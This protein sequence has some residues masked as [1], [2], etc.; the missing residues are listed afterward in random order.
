[1]SG[2]AGTD[3]GGSPS[4]ICSAAVPSFYAVAAKAS[5][6]EDVV[7][8]CDALGNRLREL[9]ELAT[10]MGGATGEHLLDDCAAKGALYKAVRCFYV[11][12]AYL[13]AGRAS[14]AY[15]VFDRGV[16]RA[17]AAR[18]KQEE[19]AHPDPEALTLLDTLEERSLAWKGIAHVE[20]VAEE[21]R[22]AANA[23]DR[24]QSLQ[25]SDSDATEVAYLMD[26]LEEW[27]SFAGV[28]SQ[29]RLCA[30]P[31]RP[32]PLPVRPFILDAALS[33]IRQPPLD[34]RAQKEEVQTTFSKLASFW[35]K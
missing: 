28:S 7:R 27:A 17:Q 25:L 21:Q 24:L 22:E 18:D 35:R 5:R 10:Q 33:Y 31:P 32:A 13:A 30:V 1:M 20:V 26:K 11:A 12:Q 15:A 19:C 2:A 6:P 29:R 34:H 9:G 3:G 23:G 8:I 4:P 16:E 14:E